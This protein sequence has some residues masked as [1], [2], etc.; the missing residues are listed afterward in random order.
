MLLIL[1]VQTLN[2]NIVVIAAISSRPYV[3]AAV[4]SGFDVIAIDAFADQ[5]TQQLAKSFFQLDVKDDRID[6]GALLNLLLTIDQKNLIGFCYGSG[7][8]MQPD[9]IDDISQ[10]M[11][12]LGNTAS[13]LRQC[14]DAKIFFKCC[15][16][17]GIPYP[18]V[19]FNEPNSKI[20][21]LTKTSGGHGGMHIR[22]LAN[23]EE[24]GMNKDGLVYFQQFQKGESVSCLFFA[25]AESF[26]II[27]FNEQ[28]VDGNQ[29]YPYRYGGAVSKASLSNLAKFRL[30]SYVK[31]LAKNLGL[32]GLNSCDAICN[33]DD[34][35]ILE[36]NPR[37]SATIDLYKHIELMKLHIDVSQT[38]LCKDSIQYFDAIELSCA[39]QVV[40]AEDDLILKEEL[41]W[42][43]WVSDIPSNKT[44]ELGA[45]ICTVRAQAETASLA[46]QMINERMS[47][48]KRKLLH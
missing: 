19:V 13:V 37:L 4:N 6:G 30:T 45:P 35:F 10:I 33:G 47:V 46:K 40:Y 34:V 39:H 43:E 20:G 24:N 38:Q 26:F 36:I 12:V 28:W 21:W 11:P 32:T 44:I 41:V 17:A 2:K 16:K 27:G 9:L 1:L 3:E 29:S 48:I 8:E 5:D 22:Q 14:K 42:P 23:V 25:S 7:F 15:N 31:V 18:S